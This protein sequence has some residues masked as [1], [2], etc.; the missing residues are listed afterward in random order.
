MDNK[1]HTTHDLTQT[2][3][4]RLSALMNL[5]SEQP[6]WSEADLAGILLHLLQT[7]ISAQTGQP[8]HRQTF[9]QLLASRRPS[10]DHLKIV[11]DFAKSARKD[12]DLGLPA[13]VAT[14]IYYA[15]LVAARLRCK[16]PISQLSDP[17]LRDGIEW[18]L[19]RT[20]LQEPLTPLFR[21]AKEKFSTR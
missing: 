4:S 13:D 20:W 19:G 2:H 16:Q 12:P 3:P 10:I 14:V 8:H 11:K 5:D 15:T 9:G 6:T 21:T 17:E 18:S 7:P 1:H